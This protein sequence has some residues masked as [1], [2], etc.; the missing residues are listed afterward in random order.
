MGMKNEYLEVDSAFEEVVKKAVN[1][2]ERDHLMAFIS[3]VETEF[4]QEHKDVGGAIVRPLKSR[5]WF[6]LAA[7][8]LLL[9][10]AFFA[11]QTFNGPS[12]DQ[13]VADY[14]EPYPN[15]Y[16]PIT[17]S[18]VQDIDIELHG[19]IKYE[20]EQY[21]EAL[22]YFNQVEGPNDD[23]KMFMAIAKLETEDFV[24]SESE[25]R[26]IIKNEGKLTKTAQWYLSLVLAKQGEVEEAKVYL[27][28]LSIQPADSFRQQESYDLLQKLK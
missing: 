12:T 10:A 15:G 9:A 28:Q 4:Q 27:Q 24:G 11:F 16:K 7:S 13:L 18:Q 23:I 19:L 2:R 17:R 20:G 25:L 3:D 22:T 14:Y 5:R 1:L 26:S 21:R 6:Q 8:L